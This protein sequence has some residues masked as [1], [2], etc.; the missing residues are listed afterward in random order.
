M[1][2]YGNY[3]KGPETGPGKI[4]AINSKRLVIN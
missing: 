4:R 2:S 3:S 1:D